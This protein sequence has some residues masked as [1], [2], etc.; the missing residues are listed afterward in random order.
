MI[1]DL[2]G[3]DTW[4]AFATQYFFAIVGV[5]ISLLL[6]SNNRIVSDTSTPYKFS[7]KFLILDN[8]K[9]VMLNML[10]IYVFIRFFKELT[11]IELSLFWCLA[12]GI[13]FD[14][15][16]EFLKNKIAALQVDRDKIN[17]P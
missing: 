14:K 6:H 8:W 5:V 13:G 7:L 15:L 9:R 11:G 10:L 12:I 2:L 16:A 17:K 3:A 1:K 4:Q